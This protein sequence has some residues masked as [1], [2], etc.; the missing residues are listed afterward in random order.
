MEAQSNKPQ[1]DAGELPFKIP[2]KVDVLFSSE[3]I[4]QRHYNYT[5]QLAIHDEKINHM[6]SREELK[7]SVNK[8]INEQIKWTVGTFIAC[9]SLMIAVVSFFFSHAS[10][11]KESSPQVIVVQQPVPV[12]SFDYWESDRK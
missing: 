11:P 10:A 7:D 6:C 8:A 4:I 3:D 1:L 12:R 2:E 9:T 5:H